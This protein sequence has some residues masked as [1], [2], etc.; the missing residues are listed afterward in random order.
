VWI[1]LAVLAAV[2][3]VGIGMAAGYLLLRAGAETPAGR[4]GARV[5]SW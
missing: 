1:A 3:L 2:V 5:T 4:G